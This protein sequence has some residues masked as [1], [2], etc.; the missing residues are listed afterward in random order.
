MLYYAWFNKWTLQRQRKTIEWERLKISSGRHLTCLLRN[1]YAGQKATV[2][3]GRGPTDWFQIVKGVHQGCILLPCL[4]NFYA[5]NLMWNAGLDESQDRVK[6]AG[7]TV[8]NLKWHHPYGRRC[9]GTKEPLDVSE[10]GEWKSWFKIQHSKNKDH[11]MLSHHFMANRWG[12]NGNS[13]RIYF[14]GLQNHCNWWL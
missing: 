14:L 12:N 4:F 9:R 5:E 13:D 7:R 3:T 1:L 10:R 2:R 6:I 11:G 8:S